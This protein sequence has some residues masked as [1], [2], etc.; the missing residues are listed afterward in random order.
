MKPIVREC[1]NRPYITK[2]VRINYLKN[3]ESLSDRIVSKLVEAITY[4][5][6]HKA[7]KVERVYLCGFMAGR[8]S[9]VSLR[10]VSGLV[11]MYYFQDS[12]TASDLFLAVQIG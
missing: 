12:P 1:S 3:E 7:A 6:R 2:V 8:E 4:E 10:K 11:Y 9:E 5:T